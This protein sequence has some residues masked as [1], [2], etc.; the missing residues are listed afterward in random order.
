MKAALADQGWTEQSRVTVLA[1]GADGLK[2][3]VPSAFSNSHSI[4]HLPNILSRNLPMN[5]SDE[6]SFLPVLRLALSLGIRFARHPG[7]SAIDHISRRSST[8]PVSVS[9]LAII[10]HR[11]RGSARLNA[12]MSMTA[13]IARGIA[14]SVQS[15]AITSWPMVRPDSRRSWAVLIASG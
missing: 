7:G 9:A 3:V 8:N 10:A 4:T 5:S 15:I 11:E 13:V 2:N 14:G 1:D 12:F 6:S